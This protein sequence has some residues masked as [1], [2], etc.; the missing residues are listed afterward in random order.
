MSKPLPEYEIYAIRYATRDAKRRDHFVGGDPHDA[1]MPMDY[2]TWVVRDGQRGS[3][4]SIAASTNPRAR[5]ADYKFL[6]CPIETMSELGIKPEDVEDVIL[7]HLHYDHVGNFHKFPKA[8][9]HMQ[10]REMAY[11]DWTRYALSPASRSRL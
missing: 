4:P 6:R 9:F 10:D 2:F 3:S 11:S 1:P 7:T 8:R 5:G